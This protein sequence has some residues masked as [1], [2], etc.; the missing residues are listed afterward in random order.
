M[1]DLTAPEYSVADGDI[2]APPP[3]KRIKDAASAI[4]I[5]TQMDNDDAWSA[6]NRAAIDSLFDG[7]P[8]Y[9]QGEREALGLGQLANF[10]S[11]GASAKE[12]QAMV[13]YV[14]LTDSEET[15]ANFELDTGDE[16]VDEI[17]GSILDFE[18]DL[19]H[20]R[21]KGFR[22]NIQMLAK[23]FIRHGVGWAYRDN[24]WDWKWKPAGWMN[25]RTEHNTEVGDEHIKI[26]KFYHEYKVDEL[27]GHIRNEK[28]AK[29]M[30]WNVNAVKQAIALAGTVQTNRQQTWYMQY[31]R[32]VR[33]VKENSFY[34]RFTYGT[35]ATN[36]LFVQEWDG[37]FS[38]YIVPYMGTV[39]DF[40]YKCEK[41]FKGIS[42]ILT[43]FT[44]GTGEGTLHTIRGMGFQIFFQEQALNRAW[45]DLLD[46]TNLAGKIVFQPADANEAET[47]NLS[48]VGPYAIMNAKGTFPNV[49]QPAVN[50]Q[51][52]PVIQMLQSDLAKNT[53][54]YAAVPVGEEGGKEMTAAEFKGRSVQQ[55]VLS[56]AQMTLFYDPLGL[57]YTETWRRLKNPRLRQSDPGGEEAF[58]FRARV[59]K[60]LKKYGLTWENIV[61]KVLRV[62][63]NRSMGNGSPQMR[64]NAAQ[65]LLALSTQMDAAGKNKALRQAVATIPGITWQHVDQYV[66]VSGPRTPQDVDIA[67]VQN[68]VFGSGVPQ[69]VLDTDNQWAHTQTH[70]DYLW[71][72]GEA[73]D[74]QQ[75][76]PNKAMPVLQE[77]LAHT[78]EHIQILDQDKAYIPEAAAARKAFQNISAIFERWQNHLM[79]QAR[80]G[81]DQQQP[82][83][84]E[85]D[86]EMQ[87][88]QASFDMEL[89]HKDDLHKQSLQQ[90]QETHAQEASWL[91]QKNRF[92]QEEGQQHLQLKNLDA[93]QKI[94][95]QSLATLVKT[96]GNGAG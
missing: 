33:D 72:V 69:P 75:M 62:Q 60:K 5:C 59:M 76:D 57:V 38:M 91:E 77:G 21:W 68:A 9:S 16:D 96:E 41:K 11:L 89:K 64:Q 47:M 51:V 12:N 13:A 84:N 30:G 79:A 26:G 45:C 27:Y 37:T 93:A 39:N 52:M 18:F 55:T 31:D 23:Q 3:G 67:A 61:D 73:L 15:I 66:P 35:V 71:K 6:S 2:L 70:L 20:D 49:A 7:Q 56:A 90:A 81:Q 24:I 28:E 29:K 80:R 4:A 54:I 46:G 43:T 86:Q 40:L 53:G 87:R 92:R 10:N 1:E 8:P 25:F 48:F 78:Q 63:P 44:Y 42:E 74:N 32:F 34:L 19:L 36:K 22:Q 83:P 17:A 88:K 50:S 65:Q 95:Q 85:A 82:Q 94:G 14:N 58:R